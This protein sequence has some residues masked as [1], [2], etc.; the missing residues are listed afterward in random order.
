MGTPTPRHVALWLSILC[1]T[2]P[3]GGCGFQKLRDVYA[4]GVHASSVQTGLFARHA[5]QT[6]RMRP[7]DLAH[8]RGADGESSPSRFP[9]GAWW[10]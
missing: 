5:Y 3:A 4:D 9:T 8:P 2:F 1:V 6:V 7:A 10:R